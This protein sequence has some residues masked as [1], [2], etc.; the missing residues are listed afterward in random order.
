MLIK[1]QHLHLLSISRVHEH[2]LDTKS[3]FKDYTDTKGQ[4][5]CCELCITASD[6]ENG[7]FMFNKMLKY[8]L[9]N[10]KKKI[11]PAAF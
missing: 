5:S 4:N 3:T 1:G 8:L 11:K 7:G 9:N 10:N 2:I 6:F